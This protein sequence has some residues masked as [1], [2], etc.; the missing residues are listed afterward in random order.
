MERDHLN[1]LSI[2]FQQWDQ[3]EIRWKLAKW[4]LKNHDFIHE[5]ITVAGKY[6]KHKAVATDNRLSVAISQLTTSCL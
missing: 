5:N 3:C 4:F 6:N 2:T 1:K